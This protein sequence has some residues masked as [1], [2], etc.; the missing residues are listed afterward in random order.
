MAIKEYFKLQFKKPEL[1]SEE[2]SLYQHKQDLERMLH[3]A[4]ARLE[5]IE[6]LNS[7]DKNDDSIILAEKLKL[8][9][10][11]FALAILETESKQSLSG[12]DEILT[13]ITE[14]EL[15]QLFESHKDLYDI[16]EK[17]S[18]TEE[19]AEFLE[20]HLGKLLNGLE[21]KYKIIRKT[22]LYTAMDT[23]SKRIWFQ[24]IVFS[25]LLALTIA[26]PAYRSI[27]YPSI[28]ADNIGIYVLNETMPQ[29]GQTNLLSLPLERKPEWKI[30]RF[31][32]KEA[33]SIDR[34]RIDPVN[35]SKMRFEIDSV[36]FLDSNSQLLAEKKFTVSKTLM[37]EIQKEIS[38]VN[39]IAPT[40]ENRPGDIAQMQSIGS[41][42]YFYL[43]TK[44]LAQVKTIEIKF[45]ITEL[46][47]KFT[48]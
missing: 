8:D 12:F 9:L 13:W 17:Y 34:I 1:N 39:Q 44:G 23:H 5:S 10:V 3:A 28:K 47:K 6:I 16:P 21:K 20:V 29:P 7:N 31:T 4:Y 22:R 30:Y 46:H 37:L 27:K 19:Q 26:V 36:R 2:N 33:Q 18:E 32:L 45:R 14:P 43:D 24:T 42:P 48:N 25:V 35:Q 41:D 11:N 40:K 38:N 15:R